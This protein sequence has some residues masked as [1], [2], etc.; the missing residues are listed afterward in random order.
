[1]AGQGTG[2]WTYFLEGASKLMGGEERKRCFRGRERESS[3]TGG[4]REGSKE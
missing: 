2:G 1:M 3:G 4:S